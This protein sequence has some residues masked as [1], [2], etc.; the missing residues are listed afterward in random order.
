MFGPNQTSGGTSKIQRITQAQ[1]GNKIH[2]LRL[3]VASDRIANS[4]DTSTIVNPDYQ[5]AT[6][7]EA[8]REL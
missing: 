8:H 5:Q 7:G 3:A 2:A 1:T 4:V 6:P